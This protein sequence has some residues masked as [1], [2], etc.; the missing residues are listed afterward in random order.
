[1]WKKLA[2]LTMMFSIFY[3][4]SFAASKIEIKGA[5]VRAIPPASSLTAAYMVI[6]NKGNE[7]DRLVKVSSIDS[8]S[9]EIHATSVNE[10]GVANMKKVDAIDIPAGKGAEL[11]PGGYHIMLIGLKKPLKVGDEVELNLKFGKAGTINVRSEVKEMTGM[12][13]HMMHDMNH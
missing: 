5:W 3:S 13:D 8:D 12:T 10:Q 2:L 7:D 6:E 11:K 1:V 4:V 9:A